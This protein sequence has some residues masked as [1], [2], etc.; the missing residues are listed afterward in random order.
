MNIEELRTY[1][2]SLSNTSEGIKWESNLAFMLFEKIY[3]LAGLEAQP[4]R[5]TF[6]VSPE[7]FNEIVGQD[8]FA[9]APY[10]AKGHWVA[11]DD[12]NK[13]SNQQLKNYIHNSYDLIKNKLPK[14]LQIQCY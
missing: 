9:Q 13:I 3:L 5:I 12:I 7:D 11:L 2:L 10:F 6:K 4:T 8:G 14:K 1:C